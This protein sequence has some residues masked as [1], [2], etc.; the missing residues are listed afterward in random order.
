MLGR[1]PENCLIRVAYVNAFCC[2]S[3]IWA[4]CMTSE[5]PAGQQQ[6]GIWTRKNASFLGFARLG[7]AIPGDEFEIVVVVLGASEG[8]FGRQGSGAGF[9]QGSHSRIS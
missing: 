8:L 2:F 7:P 5:A 9:E 4:F 3:A 6:L 1:A